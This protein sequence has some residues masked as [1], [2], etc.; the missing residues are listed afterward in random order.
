[1]A[2]GLTSVRIEFD[3]QDCFVIANGVKIAK[4]QAEAWVSIEPGFTVFDCD[5]GAGIEIAFDRAKARV[6]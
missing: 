2:K 4:R 5:D 6:Q 1:M 3:G